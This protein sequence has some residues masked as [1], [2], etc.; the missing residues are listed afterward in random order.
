MSSSG[1]IYAVIVGAWAAYLVPMWLRRQD[2]L[3][4]ARPTERFSTA[5]R[6][7]SGRGAMERRYAKELQER[8]A[9]EAGPDGEPDSRTESISSVDV[10]A[11]SAPAARTEARMEI[12]ADVP[13]PARSGATRPASRPAQ[14][15]RPAPARPAPDRA[16]PAPDRLAPERRAR[17]SGA[18]AERARRAQRLQVL[19]RRRRTTV[20][21]FLAF[22]LGTIVAAVGGLGFLW[23]PALPAVLLS[24]YIVHLRGQERRRFAFTMDRRRAEAAAQRLRENRPRRHQ[25]STAA[26]GEPDEEPEP[27]PEP[28][29]APTVSPQEAGRRA[30]VEQTD[31]AEWVDQQR[32]RGPASGDSWDPVP[33]PLPTYVTAPVAP[34]ATGGV[35]VSDPETWSAARSSTAEPATEPPPPPRAPAPRRTRDR[36]RTPLFD[37]YDEGDRP[38]AANE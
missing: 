27:G 19:A 3:N 21:L 12:R 22:T 4:E 9:E 1:L 13:A 38:R 28:A 10:R 36:G 14:A 34:R 23:A 16:A 24:V 25:S 18:A 8:T 31:H 20:I 29:P 26:A 6:L 35:E 30:L 11:F 33:V 15:S 5:I 32:E 2:E 7:L 17:P 37:Q